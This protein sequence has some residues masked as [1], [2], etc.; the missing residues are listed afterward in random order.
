MCIKDFAAR[1]V[2]MECSKATCKR[3][4]VI[5]WGVFLVESMCKQELSSSYKV[6]MYS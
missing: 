3:N 6:A 5:A 4:F 2:S 1:V